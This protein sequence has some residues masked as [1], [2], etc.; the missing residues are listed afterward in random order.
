MVV[1]AF[2][3]HNH[4]HMGPT[5]VV[6]ELPLRG[7]AIMST[8]PP[9]YSVVSALAAT[10]TRTTN[11]VVVPAF[12]VHPWWMH[13]LSDD[14]WERTKGDVEGE[15]P[16]VLPRW[17]W[18]LYQAV[19]DCPQAAVG[20]T[21][22]DGF[23]FDPTTHELTCSMETQVAAF[24]I[25][26][27]IAAKLDRPVSVHCVRSF[28][29]LLETLSSSKRA[30]TLPRKVYF[31]AFGGKVG[32]VDQLV[33]ICEETYFGFA[34]VVNFRSPKTAD[35]I[36]KIGIQRLVL[37][38]DHEDAKLVPESMESGICFL[39]E[40]LDLDRTTVIERTTENAMRLYNLSTD[41]L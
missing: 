18:D 14:D 40:A 21:G 8:Q 39:S 13:E 33:S 41:A 10:T 20:E 29:P 5:P 9:D 17:G 37:E 22:L 24:R 3:C 15:P 26:L 19:R 35:V 30:K 11:S 4:V 32:T 36:R 7:M 34:P 12:G 27:D 23:H 6:S 38:T 2:D 31:H 16:F 25:H 1:Q 28:G